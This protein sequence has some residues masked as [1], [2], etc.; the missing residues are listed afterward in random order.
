LCAHDGH[1]LGALRSSPPVFTT[2]PS[3]SDTAAQGAVIA[4]QGILLSRTRFPWASALIPGVRASIGTLLVDELVVGVLFRGA[5]GPGVLHP[6]T[7]CAPDAEGFLIGACARD[8]DVICVPIPTS[9]LGNS[10]RNRAVGHDKLVVVVIGI[11][12]H[13]PLILECLA[14]AIIIYDVCF[15]RIALYAACGA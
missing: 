14:V 10:T 4:L 7:V 3:V 9:A 5:H 11:V 6:L 2:V 8:A 12:A 13:V 1:V 15:L